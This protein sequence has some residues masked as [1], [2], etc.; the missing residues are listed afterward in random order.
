MKAYLERTESYLTGKLI[1]FW[2]Q[3]IVEPEYGGFQSNYDRDGKRTAV[4][5][6][7]LLCQGRCIFTLSHAARLGFEWDGLREAVYQGIDFLFERFR[8]PEHDGYYWICKA[9]GSVKDDSKVVYGHSFLIYGLAEHALLTGDAR[10][11]DE[12]AR[13]FDLLLARAADI[14]SGGFYEH[15]D[16]RFR[17]KS[18]RPDGRM[19]K[20]L[21]VHMH[22]ME[23]FTTLY[24]LTRDARHRQALEQVIGLIFD[25]MIHR[26]T[27]L[28][29]SIFA[30]DWT[31]LANVQLGTLWGADRFDENG[32]RP[33]I[34][35]YGHNIEFAWLYLHALDVLGVPRS[36]ALGRVEPIFEHT[37]KRGVD[38][39]LGGLYVEGPRD[40]EAT[41]TNKEFWQQ[42]EA[43]IGFLDAYQLTG[44]EKYLDAFRNVHDFV[45][46]RVINWDQ[47]EWFALLDR[48]LNVVWDYMGTSWKV[49][50]H[51]LRG[52]CQVVTKLRE[53]VGS[54]MM[55][56]E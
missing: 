16:R 44:D 56:A 14:R 30:E 54:G 46:E 11:R 37:F 17:P 29:I 33:D 51:T 34:T 10:S 2:A 48:D 35:S 47:G 50:Y 24:E 12:A 55:D 41:E 4:T 18:T 22:L 49:L 13:V 9:D 6:K 31:P 8:D 15:F 26:E 43:L 23:A 21:D 27:G 45:F 19:H 40:G 1:P 52:M 38:W 32:K 28:G 39:E 7:S 36:D 3:R 20:S 53:I 42:A 5:E 25:R